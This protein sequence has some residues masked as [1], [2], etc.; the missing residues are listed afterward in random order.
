MGLTPVHFFSHGS[1]RMLEA[2]TESGEYWEKCG[3]EALA[4]GVKGIILMGAHWAC[5]GDKIE[6]ATNPNPG[7]SFCPFVTPSLYNDWKPNP[8]IAGAERCISMLAAEGFNVGPNPDFEWI[9][10]TFMVLIRMFPDATKCPP[11]T[12]VSMNARYD[13]WYHVKVGATL[14]SLRKEGYLLVGTGGAVHNLYRNYW[15]DM[16]LYRESLGQEKP[17]EAWA[18]NFRQATEDVITKN[19]GPALRKAMI[20]LMQHPAYREAQ[21]TDDHWM[22]ALF[23][24]GAAGDFEDESEPN[25]LAAETWELRNMCNSQFTFGSYTTDS[26]G[27]GFTRE[28]EKIP[29]PRMVT[30]AA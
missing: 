15:T 21:A 14:R 11:T 20:R 28:G 26:D 6:V 30:A 7:K 8:D 10:D 19:R 18:L 22:P 3:Q 27:K 24:A 17:P 16:L 12:I 29:R 4:H 13:P 23:A 1:T 2:E 9:H 5:V 25:V